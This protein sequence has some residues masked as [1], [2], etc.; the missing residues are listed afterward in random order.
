MNFN[1]FRIYIESWNTWSWFKVEKEDK[2]FIVDIG[3][4]RIY[5]PKP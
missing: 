1:L 5:I 3:Y 4:W 2:E